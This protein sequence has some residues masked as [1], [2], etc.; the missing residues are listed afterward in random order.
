MQN[1]AE[2]VILAAFGF[3]QLTTRVSKH[4]KSDHVQR[5]VGHT[6]TSGTNSDVHDTSHEISRV[7]LVSIVSSSAVVGSIAARRFSAVLLCDTFADC[8]AAEI[9]DFLQFPVVEEEVERPEVAFLTCIQQ[10]RSCA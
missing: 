2:Q 7:S 9:G 6:F 10:A 4:P 8:S 5:H 3:A 1:P